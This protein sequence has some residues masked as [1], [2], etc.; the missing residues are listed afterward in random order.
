MPL[1]PGQ[2]MT[3]LFDFGDCWEFDVTLER[4]DPEMAIEDPVVLGEH[5]DPPRQYG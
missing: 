3:F 5:G 1:R 4:V 2:T